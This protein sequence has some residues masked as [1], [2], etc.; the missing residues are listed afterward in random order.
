MKKDIFFVHQINRIRPCPVPGRMQR[1]GNSQSLSLGMDLLQ[2]F[3]KITGQYP[4]KTKIYI[5]LTHVQECSLEH[6]LQ[7][8][9]MGNNTSD[10]ISWEMAELII[11]NLYYTI[12]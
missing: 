9:K 4:L 12:H 11:A 5:I 6:C 7:K 8:Q 2:L 3:W 10:V 1:N